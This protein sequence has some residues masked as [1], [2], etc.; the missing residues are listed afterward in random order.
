L[1]QLKDAPECD[2]YFGQSLV[3]WSLLTLAKD[4]PFAD[5]R[6][7]QALLLATDRDAI[8]KVVFQGTATP[9]RVVSPPSSW[10]YAKDVYQAAY[11]AIPAPAVDLEQ[12]KKLVEEAGATGKTITLAAQGSSIVHS[13]TADI[14]KANAAELGIDIEIKIIPVQRYGSLYWDP[15]AQE[16]I[17][18]FLS[19]WYGN[20]GD[21]LDL[22]ATIGP[23][24][25]NNYNGWNPPEAKAELD[26]ALAATD[27]T[28]RA[29][30]V[31]KVQTAFTD[32][33]VWLPLTYQSNILIMSKRIS[34]AVASFPYLYYPWA[35]TIGGV[36]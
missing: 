15:K 10:S 18:A 4:G 36:E 34:G 29:E 11:D 3:F 14:L 24:G 32:D 12:A 28:E 8:A 9:A 35:A 13:Q 25:S 17:D 2:V 33:N 30:H 1:N 27:D 21:P 5:P 22:Y 20:V 26:A 19:T 7:R 31:V 23:G 6:V 16:G